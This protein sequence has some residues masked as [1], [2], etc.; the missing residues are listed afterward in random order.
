M[1][2]GRRRFAP[3]PEP[4]KRPWEH[5]RA[6]DTPA[7][8]R[9]PGAPPAIVGHM[10][11]PASAPPNSAAGFLLAAQL[12]A[13]GIEL[14]LV[15]TEPNG[16]LVAHDPGD[17]NQRPDALS[18]TEL[19]ELLAA[20]PL[21][22]LPVLVDV[23]SAGTERALASALVGARLI[24]RAIVSTTDPQLLRRLRLAAPG[25]TRS[26][27]FP[28]SRRDPQRHHLSRRL[29]DARRPATKRL[30]PA[31]VRIAAHRHGLAAVTVN[32]RL[33]TP[34]LRE[35]TRELGIELIV[36]TVDRPEDITRM[37][38]LD[39][40]AIITN[41]PGAAAQIRSSAEPRANTPQMR[42]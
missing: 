8:M 11:A 40:D 32:H 18:I 37:L 7:R 39:V 27:T 20:P 16:V 10:G 22:A 31:I 33:V 38:E 35:V 5:L 36:W 26:Q 1:I 25:A 2:R 24:P 30:M 21:S 13:D 19:E 6:T 12:G 42:G 9:Q 17:A 23:K 3:R 4:R 41:D 29:A 28:R 34:E 14:D 15:A